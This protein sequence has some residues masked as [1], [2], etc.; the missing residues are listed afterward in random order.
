MTYCIHLKELDKRH[1]FR[2]I[3]QKSF[4]TLK[5]GLYWSIGLENSEETF[6]SITASVRVAYLFAD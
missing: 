1:F 2:L 3:M 4:R 5:P 6:F